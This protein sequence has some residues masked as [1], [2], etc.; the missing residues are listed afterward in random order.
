MEGNDGH[1]GRVSPISRFAKAIL[2]PGAVLGVALPF[3]AS[4][5]YTSRIH[6]DFAALHRTIQESHP[7]RV[8]RVV[9][10]RYGTEADSLTPSLFEDAFEFMRA[11]LGAASKLVYEGGPGYHA[12]HLA[13]FEVDG[14]KLFHVFL[15]S[16]AQLRFVPF[17]NW[18]YNDPCPTAECPWRREP[19]HPDWWYPNSRM[20]SR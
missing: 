18:E 11:E 6:A 20:V 15:W 9:H 14:G 1:H 4:T 7:G 12:Y 17:M 3:V 16:P 10:V 2:I 13:A 5:L 8:G 19:A